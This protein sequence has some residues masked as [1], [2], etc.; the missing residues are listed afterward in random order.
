MIPAVEFVWGDDWRLKV[1][2]DL[3]WND[4]DDK[5]KVCGSGVTGDAGLVIHL[6]G[7]QNLAV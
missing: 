5:K 6:I 1:E 4:G 3:W 2:A 7:E